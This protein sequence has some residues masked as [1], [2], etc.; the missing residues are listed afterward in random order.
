MT[1]SAGEKLKVSLLTL[2]DRRLVIPASALAENTALSMPQVSAGMPDWLLGHI[3]WRGQRLP[4]V[5]F[6]VVAGGKYRIPAGACI[7]I[8]RTTQSDRFIA[9]LLQEVPVESM[10]GPDLSEIAGERLSEYELAAVTL[11]GQKLLIPDLAR[12]EELLERSEV[13]E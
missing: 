3:P 9:M 2:T 12:L 5:S 4:F 6:E 10:V 11:G 1:G 8:L 7:G 13:M